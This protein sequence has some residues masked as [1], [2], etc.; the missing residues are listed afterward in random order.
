MADS[1]PGNSNVF[2]LKKGN[3][4]A[5]QNGY[6]YNTGNPTFDINTITD[7]YAD[8]RHLYIILNG[9]YTM[10]MTHP[11]KNLAITIIATVPML[12]LG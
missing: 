11:S 6:N 10:C 7:T 1:R 4:N 5:S 12:V 2:L 3:T 8:I 9:R